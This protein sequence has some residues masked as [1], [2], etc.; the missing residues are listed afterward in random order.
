MARLAAAGFAIISCAQDPTNDTP[1]ALADALALGPMFTPPQYRNSPH[2]NQGV[3]R[4]GTDHAT[5]GHPA[6][7]Q[8]SGQALHSDGTLQRIGQVKTAMLVC[9]RPAASGGASRL[10]NAVGAFVEL[11]DGDPAAAAALTAPDVLVR[12][13]NLEHSRGQS[14]AGPAFAVADGRLISRYSVTATD[15]YD[16]TAVTDPA[17]LYR[18]L[19]FLHEAAQPGSRHLL[20]FTLA[21]GQALLLANDLISHGRAAYT[22]DPDRPRLML[23]ALFTQVR[24]VP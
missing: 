11:L 2:I 8:T 13:S 9:V 18:A 6:F 4:I 12:T 1:R 15:R 10:F 22:N 23:R 3:S 16:D 21:A 14:M 24:Q 5:R 17:A 7:G 20:E 19:A